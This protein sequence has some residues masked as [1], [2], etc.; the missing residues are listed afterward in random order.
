MGAAADTLRPEGSLIVTVPHRN[1]AIS[2]KH[3]QH[4]DFSSLREALDP[5]FQIKEMLGFEND[6]VFEKLF[7]KCFQ[8]SRLFVEVPFLNRR[9][10]RAQLA[11][12]SRSEEKCRRILAKAVKR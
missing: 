3:F 8:N 2:P 5:A 12:V 9:A 7:K 1:K 6:S 10:L 11:R 4:F